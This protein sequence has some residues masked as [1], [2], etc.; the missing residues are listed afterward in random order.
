[1]QIQNL[2]YMT[3]V[4]AKNKTLVLSFSLLP[5]NGLTI[6]RRCLIYIYTILH[7]LH[8]GLKTGPILYNHHLLLVDHIVC[9]WYSTTKIVTS[10][11]KYD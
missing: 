8:V 9:N 2:Q 1:M 4:Q 5:S 11:I 3:H 7:V 10:Q 6:C